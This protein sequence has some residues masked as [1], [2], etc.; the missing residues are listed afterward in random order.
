MNCFTSLILLGLVALSLAVYTETQQEIMNFIVGKCAEEQDI[1]LNSNFTE[2]WE[3]TGLL[4][5]DEDKSKRYA[6]SWPMV[7]TFRQ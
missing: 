3:Y 4:F 6:V 1:E 5:P 7:T 2:Q